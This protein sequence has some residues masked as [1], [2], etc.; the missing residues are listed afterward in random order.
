[1]HPVHRIGTHGE[2]HPRRVRTTRRLEIEHAEGVECRHLL[3]GVTEQRRVLRIEAIVIDGRHIHGPPL[4]PLGQRRRAQ[5]RRMLHRFGA[6]PYR[7]APTGVA[8]RVNGDRPA[9]PMGSLD[10]HT[11]LRFRERLRAGDILK[12]P[13]GTIHLDPVGARFHLR[14]NGGLDI[15]RVPDASAH[16]GRGSAFARRGGQF[17]QAV[18]GHEH[19]RTNHVTAGDRITH[20]DVGVVR[21][22]K[23]AYGRHPRFERAAR[24]LRRHHHHGVTTPRSVRHRRILV[25]PVRHVRVHV[26][27]AGDRRVLAHVHNRRAGG[28]RATRTL[29]THDGVAVYEN[30]DVPLRAPRCVGECAETERGHGAR[31]T[32]DYRVLSRR[33]PRDAGKQRTA[34]SNGEQGE[35]RGAHGGA[36]S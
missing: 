11:H 10:G 21:C 16:G 31:L 34:R 2:L 9:V 19:A 17:G 13:R 27:E 7:R 8:V 23:I 6:R 22:T 35:K 26:D 5:P 25:A 36:G 29:H 14:G 1:M 3:A 18:A 20:R 24:I 28:K 12:A 30:H 15:E 33:V 32:A 4:L